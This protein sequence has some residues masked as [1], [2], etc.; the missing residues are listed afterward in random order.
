VQERQ[1]IIILAFIVDMQFVTVVTLEV[2]EHCYG[3]VRNKRVRWM[4]R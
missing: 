1:E 2:Y 4:T 3:S